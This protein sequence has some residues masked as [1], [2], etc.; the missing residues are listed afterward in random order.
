MGMEKDEA[1]RW[2]KNVFENLEGL[3]SLVLGNAPEALLEEKKAYFPNDN[4]I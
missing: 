1:K 4:R 3:R 2:F